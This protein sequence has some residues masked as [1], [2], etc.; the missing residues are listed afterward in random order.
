MHIS[1]VLV[2][3]VKDAVGL[4]FLVALQHGLEAGASCRALPFT[5]KLLLSCKQ[6]A[7]LFQY[8]DNPMAMCT[9]EMLIWDELY[10]LGY[11]PA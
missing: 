7:D 2:E 8:D 5:T 1:E 4:L 11:S 6:I 9:G 3:F 10:T